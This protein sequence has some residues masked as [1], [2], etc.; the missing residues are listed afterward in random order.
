VAVDQSRK[1]VSLADY[2]YY[3]KLLIP[4]K[5]KR[6]KDIAFTS[7]TYLSFNK[8]TKPLIGSETVEYRQGKYDFLNNAARN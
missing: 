2:K 4:Q 1:I 6:S 8:P 3:P 5:Y 7:V